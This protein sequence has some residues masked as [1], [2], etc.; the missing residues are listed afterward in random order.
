M[1]SKGTLRVTWCRASLLRSAVWRYNE[2]MKT[3]RS[4]RLKPVKKPTRKK[5][6]SRSRTSLP[7]RYQLL[8]DFI[9]IV[10]DA[11]P[12]VA[13]SHDH[14]THG[15]P[16]CFR[17]SDMKASTTQ[18]TKKTRTKKAPTHRY[19]NLTGKNGHELPTLSERFK[20]FTG[21]IKDGPPDLARNHKLYASGAKKWK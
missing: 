18:T 10:K 21:I 9:G 11:P 5:S 1:T 14:Y 13:K 15:V 17:S 6:A 2:F 12:D 3:T 20:D 8:K 4:D 19:L 16:K 7:T